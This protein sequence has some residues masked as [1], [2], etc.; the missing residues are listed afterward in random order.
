MSVWVTGE[1]VHGRWSIA[2]VDNGAGFDEETLARLGARMRDGQVAPE[3]AGE[4]V[5]IG[6]MGLVNTFA[7]LRAFY[8]EAF[9]MTLEN[10]PLG[11]RVIIGGPMRDDCGES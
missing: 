4:R 5:S 6:G 7:R 11:A 10:L 3:T 2:V 8:G 9:V 1:V